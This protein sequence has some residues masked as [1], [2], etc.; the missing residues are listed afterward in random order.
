M[1]PT[2]GLEVHAQLRT[3]SKIF[4]G[5]SAAFGA[6]PNTHV[7]PV[8]LGLPGALPV[9]NARA[10][11]FAVRAALA[12]GCTIHPVSRFARKHYFYPDLPKGYQISQYDEP[13]A[14]GGVV[15]VAMEAGPRRVGL[16][17]IHI[18]E[19]AGKSLHLDDAGTAVDFNRSGVGLIEIVT[20]PEI[21]S[22]ALAGACFSRIRDV[23]V[24]LGVNDG[25][26]EE[27][28]LRCDANVSIRADAAAPLGVKTEVKNINSFRFVQR[29][30]EFE[31]A[32]QTAMVETGQSVEP[33][34]RLW[35]PGA[36]RTIPMRNKEEAQDYRYFPEPDL[37]P[38][39]VSMAWL[40][41]ITASMPEMPDA[42][43]ERFVRDYELPEYDAGVLTQSLA[44]ADYF[45]ATA[46]ASGNPKA[47]SNWIM[48]EGLGRLNAAGMSIG[49]MRVT[50]EALARL[51]R[52]V[53]SGRITGP[54]A[55]AVFERMFAEGGDAEALVAAG[56][57]ARVDDD[58]A[59]EA[60]VRET[61]AQHPVPVA[62][63]RAGKRQA[64]GFLVGQ[65]MKSSGGRSDPAKTS[66]A[67]R[68]ILDSE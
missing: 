2:V 43:R 54:T 62:H 36:A 31:V 68:R 58:D 35:D 46:A 38:L 27:G 3:S 6:E 51:I 28:S 32:R 1:I 65:V 57:L 23:L 24:A 20:K 8:C 67:L 17:R 16:V 63:Y 18:E 37:L 25:N 26:M 14:T 60:L 5:C 10:V 44:L 29:A 13:L 55:K 64:F 66:A 4:C 48:V 30:I 19:D 7:C 47:A 53:E 34:T 11:E 40:A 49:D 12:F 42:K 56:G 45:E 41:G 39:T 33:E 52:L 21:D 50:P 59:I 22:A 61:L 9:L 15:T